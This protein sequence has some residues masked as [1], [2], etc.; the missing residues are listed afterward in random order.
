MELEVFIHGALCYSFSGICLASSAMT[1]RSG[2]RGDCAQI[3]RSFYSLERTAR[4]GTDRGSASK[5]LLPGFPRQGHFFSCRDLFLG[6]EILELVK[7][8]VDAFK[9]EGRMKSPEYVFNTVRLYREIL[10]R[11][12]ELPEEEYRDLE[13]RVELTFSRKKT[14]GFLHSPSGTRLIDIHYPGHRGSPLGTVQAVEGGEVMIT[15]E[16]DLSV[17]DGLAYYPMDDR[18]AVRAE[19]P[20]QND[21]APSET[22][23]PFIFSAHSIREM[24]KE[25]KFARRGETVWVKVPNAPADR[26]PIKGQTMYQLS[27]RFIDLPQP[28]ETSFPLYK[29]PVDLEISLDSSG[30]T[31]TATPISPPLSN[32]LESGAIEKF[33]R[34]VPLSRA[35]ER[36]S[37]T[38]VLQALF[39][40]SGESLFSLGNLTFVNG[41]G[42]PED[43]IFVP[44]S[45]LKKVKNELYRELD[46]L[47][48]KA[49]AEKAREV[50]RGVEGTPEA[51]VDRKVRVDAAHFAQRHL[52]VSKGREP[53]PFIHLRDLTMLPDASGLPLLAG[54]AF[55]PL[56]PVIFEEADYLDALKGMFSRSSGTRFAVGLSNVSHLAIAEELATF[57]NVR[58]FIDFPLYVANLHAFDFFAHR[59]KGL[60]FQYFWIEGTSE[61]YADL[62]AR[63]DGG[64]ALIAV[65]GAFRPPLFYGM[66]CLAKHVVNGES[67][68]ESESA[69]ASDRTTR[70]GCRM[71]D[72]PADFTVRL[73]QGRNRFVLIVRDCVTYLFQR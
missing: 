29:V 53:V 30:P 3:C 12:E 27:S 11:G 42:L 24:G 70:K 43:G 61:D 51:A 8:G 56:P 19:S 37:F 15:L 66:G 25:I 50:A 17:H 21:P 71:E 7:A 35:R 16:A 33:S 1:G 39:A 9:I 65:D 13:R 31:L 58:F 48:V 40:E 57:Q 72:C 47:L 63:L 67:F 45:S 49:L 32:R 20:E 36:K 60:L 44:P 73:R 64:T 5:G 23:A 22:E 68:P 55:I 69:N 38:A 41:S 6:K 46:S 34:P 54:H 62:A 52:M 59:V 14:L 10:D 18:R 26:F 4:S 2:N 28:K